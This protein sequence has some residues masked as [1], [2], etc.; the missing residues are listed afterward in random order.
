MD[1]QT[2]GQTERQTYVHTD[3]WTDNIW[4]YRWMD[5]PRDKSD[6]DRVPAFS[7]G[8]LIIFH[9]TIYTCLIAMP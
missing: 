6:Y 7:F 9:Q 5:R 1:G 3:G 8:A 4:S 2:D